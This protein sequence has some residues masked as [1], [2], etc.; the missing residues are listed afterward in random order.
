MAK[1]IDASLCLVYMAV[2]W[3][4][5][6]AQSGEGEMNITIPSFFISYDAG[7]ILIEAIKNKTIINNNDALASRALLTMTIN[8]TGEVKMARRRTY[9]AVSIRSTELALRRTILHL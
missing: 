2:R 3:R 9:S 5:I 7:E 4:V 1:T 8:G 6:M